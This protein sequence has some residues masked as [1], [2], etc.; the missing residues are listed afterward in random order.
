MACSEFFAL[1]AWFAA[2]NASFP[3]LNVR[4]MIS[5]DS[6]IFLF[7]ASISSF[8]FL[9]SSALALSAA[10]GALAVA[11]GG[12]VAVPPAFSIS[13]NV[14]RLPLPGVTVISHGTPWP[15][16]T[17]GTKFGAAV[18]WLAA[19]TYLPVNGRPAKTNSPL[20][21]VFVSYF[22]F[23]SVRKTSIC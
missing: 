4:A 10:L 16:C 11:P 6:L 15:A 5:L 1:L 17:L 18:G 2:V 23:M 7:E 13:S 8:F 14:S 12:G 20:L 21:L 9:I 3:A 19:T 22:A